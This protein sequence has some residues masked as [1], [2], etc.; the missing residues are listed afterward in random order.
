VWV[1][2]WLWVRTCAYVCL[3][4]YVYRTH[5]SMLTMAHTRWGAEISTYNVSHLQC[6]TQSCILAYVQRYRCLARVYMSLF[7]ATLYSKVLADEGS[8]NEAKRCSGRCHSIPHAPMQRIAHAPMLAMHASCAR[9]ACHGTR[10]Q[11][12]WYRA[13]SSRGRATR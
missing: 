7:H 11:P 3:Q 6:V 13:S 5:K 2:V 12:T 10:A 4:M 9:G 8:M 1:L